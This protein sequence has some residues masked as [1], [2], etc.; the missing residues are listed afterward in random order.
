MA[1]LVGYAKPIFLTKELDEPRWRL[2]DLGHVLVLMPR[3][4]SVRHV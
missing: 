4:R 1:R 2:V 3:R